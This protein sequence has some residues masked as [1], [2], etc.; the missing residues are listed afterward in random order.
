MRF[1][2]DEDLSNTV[3]LIARNLGGNTTCSHEVGRDGTTDEA[4]LTYAATQGRAIV[5]RN[6]PDFFRLTFEFQRLGL[7]HAGVLLVSSALR[8]KDF[9]AIAEAIIRYDRTH[10]DG[11]PPYMIDYLSPERD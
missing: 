2:L 7:P 8:N 6:Y 10:A 5:T 9:R 11:M 1:Y 4:Q 3:A